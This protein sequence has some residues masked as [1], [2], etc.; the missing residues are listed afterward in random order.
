MALDVMKRKTV[1]SAI[2][3]RDEE[4]LKEIVSIILDCSELSKR[5]EFFRSIVL[6]LLLDNIDLL[7]LVT[8]CKKVISNKV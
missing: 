4:R 3:K 5:N 7:E 1:L 6:K 8:F 2:R